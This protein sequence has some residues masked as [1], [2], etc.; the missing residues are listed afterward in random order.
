MVSLYTFYRTKLII[1]YMCANYLSGL[2][3]M[4]KSDMQ[5]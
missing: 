3:Y 2:I 5:L 4:K 1:N